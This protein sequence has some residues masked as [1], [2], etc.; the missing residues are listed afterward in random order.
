MADIDQLEG[1]TLYINGLQMMFGLGTYSHHSSSEQK[2][3]GEIM[4]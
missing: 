3:I 2:F 1:T 4:F